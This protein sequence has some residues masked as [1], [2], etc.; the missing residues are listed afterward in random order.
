MPHPSDPSVRSQAGAG[1]RPAPGALPPSE[2]EVVALRRYPVKGLSA[3]TL[4]STRLAAGEAIPF[5]RAYAIENGAGRFDARQPRFLPKINFLMLMRHERLA[6]L[7]TTFEEA[8]HVLT[9]FREGRQVAKGA[10]STWL[11][12]QMIEQFLA[13]YMEH[14]LKGPPR[15]VFAEGWAFANIPQKALHLVNLA[16]VRDLSKIMET[17]LDPRRFRAN[18]YFDGVEPWA[19]LNWIG[20]TLR[21]GTAL[22]EIFEPTNRCDA[23]N[24]NPATAQRDAA[25]PPT[26]KRRFGHVDLGVYARVIA[27]GD[28]KPGDSLTLFT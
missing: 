12:R 16:T 21:L 10:L 8:G 6:A 5:D 15:I 13:S 25:I 19:E 24:V 28:V 2:A 18:V 7:E 22:L 11:G 9:I 14:E 3:E 17:D 4:S 27:A 20:R 26:L 1:A 23:V